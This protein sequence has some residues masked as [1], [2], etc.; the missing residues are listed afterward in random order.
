MLNLDISH[1]TPAE[2][3]EAVYYYCSQWGTVKN[4]RFHGLSEGT[5]CDVAAVEMS[6]AE[7][8]DRL[9]Y[10]NIGDVKFGDMAIVRLTADEFVASHP[11]GDGAGIGQPEREPIEILLIEDDLRAVRK[12]RDALKTTHIRHNLHVVDDGL[13]AMLFLHRCRRFDDVPVPDIILLVELQVPGFNGDEVLSEIRACETLYNIPVVVL[14]GLRAEINVQLN[15]D[16]FVTKRQD[17]QAFA[18]EMRKIENLARPHK[19]Q[20]HV[21]RTVAFVERRSRPDA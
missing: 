2:L 20:S 15:S 12:T 1:L 5:D 13:D 11:R 8:T 3:E 21:P 18:L 7:E 19:L 9:V 14:N 6:S 10:N 4:I 16:D 17:L